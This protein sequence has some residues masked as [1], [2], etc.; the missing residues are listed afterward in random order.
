MIKKIIALLMCVMMICSVSITSY[1]A[2][3]GAVFTAVPS[4]TTVEADGTFTVTVKMNQPTASTI[5]LYL[6]YPGN[7]VERYTELDYKAD[8]TAPN[9]LGFKTYDINDD[10]RENA[11]LL[12]MY[13][14]VDATTNFEV[15]ATLGFKVK[16]G[17]TAGDIVFTMEMDEDTG[18][19][20]N[21]DD[22]FTDVNDECEYIGATVKIGSSTPVFTVDKAV[23]DGA[24]K[25]TVANAEELS[26]TG[27]IYVATFNEGVLVDCIEKP[28]VDGTIDF[29]GLKGNVDTAQMFVWNDQLVPITYTTSAQ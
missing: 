8:A 16:S 27:S 24:V 5:G 22:N 12:A 3:S 29:T 21:D 28:I 15:V 26:V 9:S 25:V 4:V 19:G 14:R 13:D 1:A 18:I 11:S 23:V 17:V 20:W 6:L 7:L 10:Y 2:M